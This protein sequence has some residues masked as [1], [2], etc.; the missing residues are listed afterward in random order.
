MT[1]VWLKTSAA[2]RRVDETTRENNLVEPLPTR[3]RARSDSTSKGR[4]FERPAGS[5]RVVQVGF[6]SASARVTFRFDGFC[7]E[8]RAP[9]G[10]LETGRHRTC[11][12]GPG[13][14]ATFLSYRRPCT[15]GKSP[16]EAGTAKPARS[17]SG[18]W[19]RSANFVGS[20]AR[21]RSFVRN[22]TG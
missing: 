19:R 3:P 6:Q 17:K 13:D 15:P 11:S 7:E 9:S 20:S 18:G 1:G 4:G 14:R 2:T 22:A 12:S 21:G 5:R 16:R 8:K 10:D